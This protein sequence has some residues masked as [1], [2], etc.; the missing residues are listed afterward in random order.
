MSMQVSYP[1]SQFEPISAQMGLAR[2]TLDLDLGDVYFN[3]M[4]ATLKGTILCGQ[5]LTPHGQEA[6]LRSLHLEWV[7]RTQLCSSGIA[8]KLQFW[9]LWSDCAPQISA[10]RASIIADYCLMYTV[11]DD[12]AEAFFRNGS[13]LTLDQALRNFQ[14]VLTGRAPSPGA[15]TDFP[16]YGVLCDVLADLHRRL[17]SSETDAVLQVLGEGFGRYRRGVVQQAYLAQRG[18]RVSRETQLYNRLL[19]VAYEPTITLLCIVN[20]FRYPDLA[21]SHPMLERLHTAFCRIGAIINDIISFPKEAGEHAACQ[22]LI[23]A[24]HD[25]LVNTPLHNPL[26]TAIAR[27][28]EFHNREFEDC[29]SLGEMVMHDAP[30]LAPFVQLGVDMHQSWM[31]WCLNS[32]RYIVTA[33]PSQ[34][35]AN[36]THASG[37]RYD[38]RALADKLEGAVS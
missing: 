26:Q 30:S 38:D 4:A 15:F 1:A 20:G 22:N 16:R 18:Q 2:R 10:E 3:G 7:R 32:S 9:K 31:N 21:D 28:V 24:Y 33:A 17:A 5:T 19:N 36:N 14:A 27:T 13:L 29:L 11:L 37:Q 25:E 8:A 35:V 12:G 34:S 6:E 23:A